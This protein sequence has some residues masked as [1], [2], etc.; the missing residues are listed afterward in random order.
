MCHLGPST[1]KLHFWVH[2]LFKWFTV[3]LYPFVWVWN[4]YITP[5]CI[6]FSPKW[7]LSHYKPDC[8]PKAQVLN[9]RW[10]IGGTQTS[11]SWGPCNVD[12]ESGHMRG[13]AMGGLRARVGCRPRPWAEGWHHHGG[14]L[15]NP[16]CTYCTSTSHAPWDIM[17]V[18]IQNGPTP[19]PSSN[20]PADAKL[21]Y[22]DHSMDHNVSVDAH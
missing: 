1:L 14:V 19:Q 22:S 8:P 13:R 2:K 12:V 15:A 9:M 4:L 18:G 16:T 20:S 5:L 10:T 7:I 17:V 21:F 6:F 11:R 3:G